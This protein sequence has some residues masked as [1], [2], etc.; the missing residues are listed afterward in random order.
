[1]K[2]LIPIVLVFVLT[3]SMLAGCRSRNED[4]NTT[5]TT[6]SQGGMLPDTGD[7][8]P[9]KNDKIDPTNGANQDATTLPTTTQPMTGPMD[10]PGT[11]DVP[12]NAGDMGRSRRNPMG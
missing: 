5:N 8:L 11:T 10:V 1:M 2:R 7:I 12:G 6:A 4:T 9:D 3:V